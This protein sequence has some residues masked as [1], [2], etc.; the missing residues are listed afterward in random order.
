TITIGN[1][2]ISTQPTGSTISS[3]QTAM[4][5]VVAAGSGT[6]SYQW[7]SGTSGTTTS[8]IGGPTSSSYTTP[9]LTTGGNYHH[10]AGV[11]N[12]Y[13]TGD[14]STATVTVAGAPTITQQPSSSSICSGTTQTLKAK[15]TTSSGTLDY[16]WYTGAS[17]NT[18]SPAGTCTGL[19]SGVQC[20]YT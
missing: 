4:M 18:S 19:A 13:G 16:Q 9:T 7:Y 20:S 6:L 15:A 1:P 10:C 14:S 12:A 3:G 2:T 5:S 8:P 11:S 17:G